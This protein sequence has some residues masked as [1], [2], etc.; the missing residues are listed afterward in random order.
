[1]E[2]ASHGLLTALIVDWRHLKRQQYACL[3]VILLDI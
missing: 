3:Y 1:M 2:I